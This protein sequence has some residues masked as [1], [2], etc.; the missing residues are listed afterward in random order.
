MAKTISDERFKGAQ[1]YESDY[2][3]SRQKDPVGI[4]HDLDSVFAL[5]QHL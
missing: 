3:I 5:A 4:L 2:W 1:K